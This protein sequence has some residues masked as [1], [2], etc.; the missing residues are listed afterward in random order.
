MSNFYVC[1]AAGF[2]TMNTLLSSKEAQFEPVLLV[3]LVSSLV[4]FHGT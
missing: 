4:Y 1:L 2:V 3:A